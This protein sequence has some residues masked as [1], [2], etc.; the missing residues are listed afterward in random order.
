MNSDIRYR[1]RRPVPCWTCQPTKTNFNHYPTEADGKRQYPAFAFTTCPG[2][3][4][5]VIRIPQLIDF[6]R[7]DLSDII[8]RKPTGRAWKNRRL[9]KRHPAVWFVAP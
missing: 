6:G 8:R 9:W 5:S 7:S 3:P 2:M 1:G 4:M